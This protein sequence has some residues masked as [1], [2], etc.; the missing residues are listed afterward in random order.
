VLAFAPWDRSTYEG[1]SSRV[2]KRFAKGLS[3]VASFTYGRSLD[4]QNPAL[5][6]CD[7]CESGNGI[8]NAYNRNGQKGPSDQNVPV[9]LVFGGVWDLPFGPGHSLA[10]SG[11]AGQ[12]VRNWQVS[13]IY[14]V[15]NGLPF[16]AVLSFDNANAG[17]TSWPD[18]VCN[19]NLSSPAVSRWYNADCFVS[20]AQ[21]QFGDEGRNVLNGPRRNNVDFALHRSFRL[22]G[23]EV[24][25]LEFRT[26]AYNL[27][28]HPQF[29]FPGA[30]IGTA[31][32]GVISATAV[33]N[34]ILQFALRL[35]F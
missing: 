8:Q 30:T 27:F 4:L 33:P 7:G 21:Y 19:G 20:P 22:P 15:Q 13:G 24:L 29:Q 25:A 2:E 10:S 28:N 14:Q 5:G 34:R 6:V 26:E 11:L 1:L 9:R 32:A 3:F 31:S 35:A 12:V 16:T 18:R 17:N 23:R